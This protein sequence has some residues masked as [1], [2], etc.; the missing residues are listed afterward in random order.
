MSTFG[1]P[2][3]AAGPAGFPAARRPPHRRHRQRRREG[4]GVERG[5]A[6]P[7]HGRSGGNRG[8]RAAQAALAGAAAAAGG[9]QPAAK[10]ASRGAPSDRRIP[11]A[12]LSWPDARWTAMGASSSWSWAASSRCCPRAGVRAGVAPRGGQ[13]EPTRTAVSGR[14]VAVATAGKETIEPRS[15]RAHAAASRCAG[16]GPS[17]TTQRV[18]A[19]TSSSP[20]QPR[21]AVSAPVIPHRM[22]RPASSPPTWRRRDCPAERGWPSPRRP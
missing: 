21:V 11:G 13:P 12:K 2:C 1:S 16:G 5:R 15:R 7:A 20:N 18:C 17:P 8:S 3:T 19:A 6:G 9:E 10:C 4:V 14:D 22:Q